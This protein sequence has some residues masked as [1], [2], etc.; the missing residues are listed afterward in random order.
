MTGVEPKR[1]LGLLGVE[2]WFRWETEKRQEKENKGKGRFQEVRT[3]A[4]NAM[5]KMMEA[6]PD[7]KR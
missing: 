5:P 6:R 7:R 4:E 2:T 1:S 3:T